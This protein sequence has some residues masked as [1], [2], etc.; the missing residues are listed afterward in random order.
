MA[1]LYILHQ[2]IAVDSPDAQG[3][4]SLMWAAYQGDAISVELLL[5]HGAS[6]TSKDHTGLTALH[7]AVV[8]GNKV[9]IR[10]LIEAGADLNA[11]DENGKTP[12]EMAIE[13]K[14]ISA[15]KRALEEGGMSEDGHRKSKPLNDR[16]TKA[17]I[18]IL[19]AFFFFLIFNTFSI[20]PWFTAIP[21]AF[22]EFFGMHH[23]V[24]RVL[25]NHKNY[26]ENL[27]HSP[28]FSGIILGSMWWV[29]Y[30]WF[31]RL[32]KGRL[33]FTMFH[34]GLTLG[35]GTSGY[36]FTHLA[37]AL[38]CLLCA[39][40]FFRS[41]TLD[42]GSCPKPASDAE[43]KMVIEELA[44]QGR[45]NGQTFCISCMARKPLRSKHCRVCDRCVAR[46]D[47]H[48]PWVWNCVGVN[49]HRQFVIFV[50]TL[51]LGIVLFDYLVF[52]YF[53]EQLPTSVVDQPIP[54]LFPEAICVATQFDAFLFTVAAW[55]SLQLV[56]TVVLLAGQ[57]WQI[58]RQ[59][60]TLEV[61]NLG[62]YGWMGG[63]GGQSLA[64]QQ[65][66]HR[67]SGLDSLAAA[68]GGG[69]Q[70]DAVITGLVPPA[71]HGHRHAG[72]LGLL[73]NL[74]GF[75][76]FTRGRAGEGL[77]RAATA[78]N[79]FDLGC[80]GNCHDFWTS[81]RELGVEYGALYEVPPEGFREAKRRAIR[82]DEEDGMGRR[83]SVKG[84]IGLGILGRGRSSRD[85]YAP[86]RMD[87]QV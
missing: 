77:A 47:H 83:R 29:A 22:A 40:N 10:K 65:G 50:T 36:A 1:L 75:D 18:L 76:R 13:L 79:P 30:C 19:P 51:V 82:E 63:R 24:T 4:T 2:P 81:G 67:H 80:M 49:N 15:Y 87:D 3:H 5:K 20:L 62:R 27:T 42:A 8:R 25:L 44:T 68:A 31:T 59:M 72:L 43:L 84:F 7:W 12:R 46:F 17:A 85:G 23:I 45:L 28:Y 78:Q 16:N 66:A 60:T 54:C 53:T 55:V 57:I 71:R 39:Y 70:D 74:M 61:S 34:L 52:A 33:S 37:F 69:D 41:I 14:S 35:L 21:L 56:W 11:R 48:C 38:L 32:V 86:L 64:S 58:A 26:T 6:V 73:M 9:C